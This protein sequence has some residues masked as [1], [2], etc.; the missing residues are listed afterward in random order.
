MSTQEWEDY[1]EYMKKKLALVG[2]ERGF[3]FSRTRQPKEGGASPDVSGDDDTVHDG[4]MVQGG[5][6][7][8]KREEAE[9]DE[10]MDVESLERKKLLHRKSESQENGEG[11]VVNSSEGIGE[12]SSGRSESGLVGKVS[13]SLDPP[14]PAMSDMADGGEKKNELDSAGEGP[15]VNGEN[16]SHDD[17]R[18]GRKEED[19]EG[20]GGSGEDAKDEKDTEGGWGNNGVERLLGEQHEKSLAVQN[21]EDKGTAERVPQE[22]A[23]LSET[24]ARDSRQ[25][26]SLRPS[27]AGASRQ[28]QDGGGTGR[29]SQEDAGVFRRRQDDE[30]VARHDPAVRRGPDEMEVEVL[31]EETEGS[32]NIRN[33]LSSLVYSLGLSEVETKKLVALWHNRVI[34]PPL[35]HTQLVQDL[36]RRQ[37]LY[38]QEHAHFEKE[39]EKA[40]LRED[41]VRGQLVG[42]HLL[43]VT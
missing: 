34:I 38:Q 32:Q 19:Y 13:P 39:N 41:K 37:E 24:N 8:V 10:D 40:R 27:N 23:T 43:Y 3:G 15:S 36:A 35:G 22:T 5:W 14:F 16:S 21:Q 33:M 2:K 7:S 30:E 12:T 20:T 9:Q 29:Q 1:D 17:L 28:E 18:K 26:G 11:G 42:W 25:A 31:E 6:S 4:E